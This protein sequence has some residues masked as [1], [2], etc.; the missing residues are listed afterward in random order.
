[1]RVIVAGEKHWHADDL[2]EDVV[3]RLLRRYGPS[4]V[5]VHGGA[6]GID[7]S[8]ALACEELGVEVE[9]L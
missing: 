4:L 8:F 3:T 1:M 2:A 5:I 7:H 6:C 9:Q